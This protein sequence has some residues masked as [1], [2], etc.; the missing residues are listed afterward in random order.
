MG[1]E[2]QLTQ[3]LFKIIDDLLFEV[4]QAKAVSEEKFVM[5]EREVEN[6]KSRIKMTI[7]DIVADE[8]EE[9]IELLQK[10]GINSKAQ[11]IKRLKDKE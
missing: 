5:L 4:G 7:S 3:T 11:V 6:S 10:E 1:I 9:M 8:K 2:K